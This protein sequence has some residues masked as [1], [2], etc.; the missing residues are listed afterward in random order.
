[1]CSELFNPQ[2]KARVQ[3]HQKNEKKARDYHGDY[4]FE[5]GKSKKKYFVMRDVYLSK[6]F[7][8]KIILMRKFVKLRK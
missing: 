1:M 2:L 4:K 5:M 7:S 8:L 6:N 3:I